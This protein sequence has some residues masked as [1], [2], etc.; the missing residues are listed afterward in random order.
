MEKVDICMTATLRP[1]IIH[2]TLISFCNGLFT[3][4]D[5]YRLI[6]NVDPIGE[7]IKRKSIADICG[8]FF[9][10]VIYNFPEKPSFPDAVK[11]VWSQSSSNFVFHLEDDWI[12]TRK[13]DI[14]DMIRILNKDN[15]VAC[16]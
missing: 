8:M 1:S 2:Q 4:R 10:D 3:E 13:L 16:L 11:W 6:V 9:K 15:R 12:L 7:K 5:N 14:N